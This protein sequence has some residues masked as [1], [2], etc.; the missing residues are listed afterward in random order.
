MTSKRE[1]IKQAIKDDDLKVKSVDPESGKVENKR[2][3]DVMRHDIPDDKDIVRVSLENG[4]DVIATEDHSLFTLSNQRNK[5]IQAI[6]ASELRA[7]ES[8]VYVEDNTAR[9]AE[10]ASV[11]VSEP[12]DYMYDLSVEDNENF[13]LESGILAHN[14]YSIGGIS[15]DID[16]S[17][18]YESLKSNAEDQFQKML[19]AKERTVNITK[20]LKQSRYGVGV[21]S[22]FGPSTSQGVMT[23]RK[24]LGF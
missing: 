12:R 2:I 15:L 1:K 16:K 7:G 4:D 8:L 22:S 3:K 24:Y 23:P 5:A 14:S 21:R 6:E 13:V 19:E 17:S 11:T 9:P 10:I 20:G 18:K